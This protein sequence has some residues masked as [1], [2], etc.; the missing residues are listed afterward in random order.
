MISGQKTTGLA[1]I[2]TGVNRSCLGSSEPIVITATLQN[3]AEVVHITIDIQF[4]D[5]LGY[6]RTVFLEVR[7]KGR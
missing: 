2:R 3:R 1:R 6:C 5:K 4:F 7:A